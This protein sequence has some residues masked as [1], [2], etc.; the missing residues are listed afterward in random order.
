MK[1]VIKGT[2]GK[3]T[4]KEYIIKQLF[5]HLCDAEYLEIDGVPG[6]KVVVDIEALSPIFDVDD[7]IEQAY[8]SGVG[9]VEA[10]NILREEAEEM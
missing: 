1:R 4:S 5:E 7:V 10:I 2:T 3:S 8:E 9:I 6:R